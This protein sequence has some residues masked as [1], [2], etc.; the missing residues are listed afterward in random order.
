MLLSTCEREHDVKPL[1]LE[2]NKDVEIDIGHVRYIYCIIY[3]CVKGRRNW[4]TFDSLFR[5]VRDE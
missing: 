2:W 3:I 5:E 4:L 1:C